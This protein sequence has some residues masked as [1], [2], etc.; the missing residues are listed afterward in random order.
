M[1]TIGQDID[2]LIQGDIDGQLEADDQATLQQKMEQNIQVQQSYRDYRHLVESIDELPML[3]APQ[4]ITDR[5]LA[6]SL[7]FNEA[8]AVG[9]RQAGP[10]TAAPRSS[11]FSSWFEFPA[12]RYALAFAIGAVFAGS[13]LQID[14]P[15]IAG[16]GSANMVGTM[17]A[18]PGFTKF[19]SLDIEHDVFRGRL[20]LLRAEQ[21]LQLRF[22]LETEEPLQVLVEF[23]DAVH[24]LAGFSQEAGEGISVNAEAGRF[25]IVTN[26]EQRLNLLLSNDSKADS[27]V[28]VSF[29][30][31]NEKIEE[32][33]IP[34]PANG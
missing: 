12:L 17:S 4:G 8:S 18:P 20:E 2:E 33:L 31:N 30:R 5:V 7:H 28:A 21:Q 22:A 3:E 23:T 25:A 13:L 1:S 14:E 6:S 9:S 34:V 26:G 19:S 24:R 10:H 29:W 16:V 15:T 32:M 27:V 11:L